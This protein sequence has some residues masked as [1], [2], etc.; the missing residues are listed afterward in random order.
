M[1]LLELE[2]DTRVAELNEEIMEIGDDALM[3]MKASEKVSIY[4]HS[5]RKKLINMI[6]ARYSHPK[7]A[8]KTFTSTAMMWE[9]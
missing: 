2:H 4:T 5:L 1:E 9:F 6:G 3:Q 7:G 8:G